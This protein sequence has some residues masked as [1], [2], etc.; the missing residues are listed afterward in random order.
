MRKKKWLKRIGVVIVL[1]V[2]GG[3]LALIWLA[4][5]RLPMVD[6]TLTHPSLK[7]SVTVKRDNFGVPHITADEESDAYFTLGYAMGQDRLFQMELLRRLANGQTAEVLG[8]RLV[9]VDALTRSFQLRPKAVATDA[10]LKATYPE[11]YGLMAAFTEGINFRME[12]ESLPFE[13][14]VL[15][16]DGRPFTVVDCL[17]IGALLPI[18]FAD[19]L[20]GDPLY[21]L[22]EEKLPDHDIS[23]LFPGYH[24]ET[25][26]TIMETLE[27]AQAYLDGQT[28]A[29]PA[30]ASTQGRVAGL[31]DL[32]AVLNPI[33][34]LYGPALGSNSWLLAPS[35]SKSGKALFANDP[36]IGFTN[37]SIWYEAQIT[38]PDH[39]LYGYYLP[40]VPVALLGQ[41]QHHAW[42][43]TM[44][45]NDDVDL[46]RETFME[47]DPSQVL[48]KSAWVPVQTSEDTIKVRWGKDVPI[49]M[50]R[51][52]HGPVVTD[53]LEALFDYE[54]PDVSLSWVWQQVDYTDM[55]AF[56]Q[57]GRATSYEEFAAAM[58]LVTSPGINVSYA[59][60]DDN[61]AWWAAGKIPIRPDHVNNKALLEGATGNDE[62]LGFV[63][64]SENPHLH[65][66]PWGYIATANN[67][68][69]V[70]PVGAVKDLQGYW[71]PGDRAGRI[72]ELLTSQDK[73]TLEELKAIQLDS[74][75]LAAP[76]IVAT[77]TIALTPALESFS[78]LESEAFSLLTAWDFRHGTDSAGAAIYQL[79]CTMIMREA[80]LDEMGETYFTTYGSLADHWNFFKRFTASP[81]SVYWD[82][83]STSQKETR[84]QIITQ[85]FGEAVRYLEST[86]GSDPAAWAWGDLHQLEFKH[87][88]GFIPGLSGIFNI[89]PFPVSGGA[90]Q[91]NNMLYGAGELNF[92][93]IAGP[94]TRR[95]VDFA[96]PTA[97]HGILPTGNSGN[98][99]S[100]HY[101][102]QAAM[103]IEG[104]YRI[105]NSTPTN[106]DENL[107]STLVFESGP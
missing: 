105:L 26:V 47:G 69:T 85:A 3:L 61:I 86:L 95:L 32:L 84:E 101:D 35:R 51:T 53:L 71:Q 11:I 34:E 14:A 20:R 30:H 49:A 63:P 89:G 54:G 107:E 6:G 39:D 97:A 83:I 21:S 2:A 64:F 74:Q 19:G 94:S 60:V 18:T 17:S 98:F 91:V 29:V 70:K 88:F 68:S 99:M 43:L 16:L 40:L 55:I 100:P 10:F 77:A 8:E 56:Y 36:H 1:L 12:N 27:E 73:W 82:N 23:E 72:E 25:P 24:R 7:A 52:E 79:L 41:N 92:D 59:D 65:N 103:F 13:F 31:E 80:L 81:D 45:A 57:M 9:P 87:P 102:D 48:Y 76:Q 28:D 67:K 38:L 78:P 5:S 93:V 44:F 58:P 75:A 37:P 62:V 96:D 66:P 90:Q 33:S 15:D 46:Y 106:V 50:R 22:L 104:T 4:K 42:G